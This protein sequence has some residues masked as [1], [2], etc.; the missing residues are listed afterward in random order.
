MKN[1]SF[2]SQKNV[3][4]TGA[5]R[6]I[7]AACAQH[8]H[9]QGCNVIIH[10]NA[11]SGQ[12]RN[13]CQELNERRENSAIGIKADLSNGDEL[14]KLASQAVE[15]WGGLD[16]LVNNASRF[17]S[18]AFGRIRDEDWDCLVNSNLKAPFFLS[19]ALSGMLRSRHGCIVNLVDIYGE[20]GLPDYPVYSI[21]KAGLIAMTKCLAKEL[22]PE[23]RVNAVAPGA[24][25]WPEGEIDSERNREILRRI[26]LQRCGAVEDIAKAVGFLIFEANYIT[27]HILTVDGGRTLFV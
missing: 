25:L 27:G 15:A 8:L 22:A 16:V 13:L 9:R 3:L 20:K 6:R 18:G 1:P 12:A 11:S 19:Q 14:R 10:F 2:P 7:G 5:A 21:T 4:I 17:D 26:A 23:V 24:I